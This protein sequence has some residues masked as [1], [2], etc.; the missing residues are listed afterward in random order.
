MIVDLPAL[1]LTVHQP[2]LDQFS[3]GQLSLAPAVAAGPGQLSGA[4]AGLLA[5]D[6]QQHLGAVAQLGVSQ[7]GSQ[8]LAVHDGISREGREAGGLRL[9]SQSGP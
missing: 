2:V 4:A 7:E 5:Q 1:A 6:H 9:G 8:G 3:Q